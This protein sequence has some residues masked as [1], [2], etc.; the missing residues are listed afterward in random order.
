[1]LPISFIQLQLSRWYIDACYCFVV[2]QPIHGA[3]I[4]LQLNCWHIIDA[5][6]W[7]LVLL[8]SFDLFMVLA[9]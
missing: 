3:F 2:L 1:L 4:Q 6:Y 5:Y 7:Q 8:W 9:W